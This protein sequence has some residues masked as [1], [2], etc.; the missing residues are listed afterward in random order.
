MQQTKPQ[1]EPSSPLVPTQRTHVRLHLVQIP[2]RGRELTWC[3]SWWRTTLGRACPHGASRPAQAHD[4]RPPSMSRSTLSSSCNETIA[5]GSFSH[6]ASLH[7]ARPSGK[8]RLV[9]GIMPVV[10]RDPQGKASGAP[11]PPASPLMPTTT[12]RSTRMFTDDGARCRVGAQPTGRSTALRMLHF[13]T[14]L[15]SRLL[16]HGHL[17]ATPRKPL[18]FATSSLFIANF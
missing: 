14:L 3:P 8:G 9:L 11:R 12:Q 6:A 7:E 17:S 15:C 2:R 18:V 13:T 5:S 10:G 16:D 4:N 1:L